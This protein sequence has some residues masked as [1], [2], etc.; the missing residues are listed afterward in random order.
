MNKFL[1]SLLNKLYSQ[2]PQLVSQTATPMCLFTSLPILHSNVT[3]KLI[4]DSLK[5][6]QIQL[7]AKNYLTELSSSFDTRVKKAVKDFQHD[8]DLHEDG[9]VGPLTWACLYHPQLSLHE[10]RITSEK[11]N[12]IEELH[13]L[14][15][16][17]GFSIR[18]LNGQYGRDTERA[19]RSFQRTYGLKPDGMVGPWTWAILLGVRHKPEQGFPESVYLLLRQNLHLLE[20]VVMV[21]CI[22]GGIYFSPLSRDELPIP[23][24]LITSFALACITPVVLDLLKVRQFWKTNPL[25]LQYAPYALTGILWSP[26]LNA[27]LARIN[28]S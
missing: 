8:N 19:V 21:G 25:I 6:L 24:T 12:A 3:Q 7:K 2:Q 14:L 18:D 1:Q 26:I 13:V 20:Q 28:A 9:I 4:D 15:R 5:E 22:F 10:K 23:E 27:V 11:R 17:E 16:K